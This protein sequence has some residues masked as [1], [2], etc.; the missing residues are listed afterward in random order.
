MA[1]ETKEQPQTN[2]GNHNTLKAHYESKED[3][4][5]E[6]D[7]LYSS[8]SSFLPL[9]EEKHADIEKIGSEGEIYDISFFGG[10]TAEVMNKI[11]NGRKNYDLGTLECEGYEDSEGY[12]LE[13]DLNFDPN[14]DDLL[15][16]GIREIVYSHLEQ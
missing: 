13:T 5:A 14:T 10:K 8:L 2:S 16:S 15:E 6:L 4:L 9:E 7:S 11:V 12:V 1:L 3:A